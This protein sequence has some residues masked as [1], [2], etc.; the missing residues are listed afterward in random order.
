MMSLNLMLHCQVSLVHTFVAIGHCQFT[1]DLLG[2]VVSFVAVGDVF[3]N[4]FT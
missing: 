3:F 4:K 2:T 1:V